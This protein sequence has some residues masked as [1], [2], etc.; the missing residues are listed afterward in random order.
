MLRMKSD[1]VGIAVD[2]FLL[3]NYYYLGRHCMC[4]TEGVE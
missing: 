2:D 1:I 4:V 3:F